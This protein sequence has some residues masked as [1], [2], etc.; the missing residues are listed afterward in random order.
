MHKK[1]F[2]GK[3]LL[4]ISVLTLL[5]LLGNSAFAIIV[6][7]DPDVQKANKLYLNGDIEQAKTLLILKAYEGNAAAQYNLAV[8]HY[9]ERSNPVDE[10]EFR[11]WLHK[12]A[13]SGD[14]DAQFNYAMQIFQNQEDDNRLKNSVKWLT[15]AAENGHVKSQYN[16]GY[17]A[18]SNLEIGISR[19]KGVEWLQKSGSAGDDRSIKLMNMLQNNQSEGAPKLYGVNFELK[20]ILANRIYVVKSDNTRIYP[21]TATRQNPLRIV[22]SGARVD[23]KEKQGNWLG[24]NVEGGYPSWVAKSE[25]DITG[26]S[27]KVVGLEASLFIEPAF[28]AKVF[29]IGTVDY[30][31]NLVVLGQEDGW[32]KVKT[33]TQFLAW[34]QEKDVLEISGISLNAIQEVPN[35]SLEIKQLEKWYSVYDTNDSNRKLLGIVSADH[36]VEVIKQQGAFSQISWEGGIEAWVFSKFVEIEGETGRVVVD[37]AR[38][39]LRP[40]PSYSARVISNLNKNQ[41]FKVTQ[42]TQQSEGDWHRIVIIPKGNGWVENL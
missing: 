22:D 29:K 17:L 9:K 38:A 1:S 41:E 35:N 36:V 28:N 8:I 7:D 19:L 33:P 24:V 32:V 4:G 23:I 26:R 14:L 2:F 30:S 34:I 39:L 37:N 27:A 16:L 21:F 42:T 18:F 25:I 3:S 11:F 20:Q 13:D 6:L 10:K 5:L 31:E 12:A 15:L 40:D